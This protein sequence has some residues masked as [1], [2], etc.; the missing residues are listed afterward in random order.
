MT[1]SST[2]AADRLAAEEA[3]LV[4]QIAAGDVGPPVAALYRRYGKRLYRFGVNNLGN[5][6]L[7]EEM[8][9]ETF[10]RLWR[11]ASRF[12]ADKASVGTYLYVIA[13]S[14]AADIRKRP[15]SRP[16]QAVDEAGVPP[17]ADGVDEILDSMIVREAFETLGPAHAEV[18]RL[19]QDEGL[20]QS[21]IADRL[22]L[23]LGTV[24]TRTFH[25]M[26]ALRTA[27]IERGFHAL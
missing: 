18:I 11:T 24:K 4:A 21:Q 8:V 5:E 27:L 15:S 1:V 16:L 14:V 12:D 23:P 19:A 6:G 10:V 2:D 20:T 17:Q 26:R 7:A 25:G 9:Q 22:G 3:D 13:R